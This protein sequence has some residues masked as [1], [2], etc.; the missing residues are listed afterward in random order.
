MAECLAKF[1]HYIRH[2]QIKL[3][4]DF[5]LFDALNTTAI[6]HPKILPVWKRLI[7]TCSV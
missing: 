5:T 6:R 2:Y 3:P 4:T 7:V 1:E